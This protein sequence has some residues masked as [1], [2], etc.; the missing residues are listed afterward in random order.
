MV[1][2]IHPVLEGVRIASHALT[3]SRHGVSLLE[4]VLWAA[5]MVL[6]VTVHCAL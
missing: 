1:A 5:L 6:E 4:Y 3:F 2:L